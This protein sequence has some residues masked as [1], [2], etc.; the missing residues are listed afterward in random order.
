MIIMNNTFGIICVILACSTASTS[1]A[2]RRRNSTSSSNNNAM[3][4]LLD[5]VHSFRHDASTSRRELKD[6]AQSHRR[7][8]ET[9]TQD[10]HVRRNEARNLK[11]DK[12]NGKHTTPTTTATNVAA[13]A[14][15][16]P[17]SCCEFLSTLSKLDAHCYE[18]VREAEI[19][20]ISMDPSY[21]CAND[22]IGKRTKKKKKKQKKGGSKGT[23]SSSHQMSQ[24]ADNYEDASWT[25]NDYLLD[26]LEVRHYTTSRVHTHSR[27]LQSRRLHASLPF[28]IFG[29]FAS[30]AVDSLPFL[31][32]RD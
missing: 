20:D 24:L 27:L 23:T 21:N 9:T 3:N 4:R 32:Y 11:S 12:K 1:A 14:N 22:V 6:V 13:L 15:Y 31:L 2:S 19:V 26:A 7:R 10:D 5:K 30:L 28:D 8:M 17:L 16:V 29:C 18:I 25:Y